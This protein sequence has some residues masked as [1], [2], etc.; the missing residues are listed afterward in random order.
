MKSKRIAFRPVLFILKKEDIH[1]IAGNRPFHEDHLALP[2]AQ[3]PAFSRKIFYE[4][5]FQYGIFLS[6]S[7]GA[8]VTP[9]L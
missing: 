7:H 9:R 5:F 6:F 8:K 4:Q 1:D 3:R 2:P